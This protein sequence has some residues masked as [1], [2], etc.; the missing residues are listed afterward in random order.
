MRLQVAPLAELA[1]SVRVSGTPVPRYE[2]KVAHKHGGGLS[3]DDE[4]VQRADGA[5][6]LDHLEPGAYQLTVIADAGHV[7]RPLELKAGEH[8]QIALD[9]QPWARLRGL[10]ID[11][12]APAPAIRN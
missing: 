1:G 10:L 9:L 7:E 11:W 12:S 6:Q 4:T 3:R 2:L 8:A 5:F